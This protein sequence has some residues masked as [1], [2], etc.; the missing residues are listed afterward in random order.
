MGIAMAAGGGRRAARGDDV[1]KR[2][3]EGVGVSGM[4]AV[5]VLTPALRCSLGRHRALSGSAGTEPPL[6][7][8]GRPGPFGW[9]LAAGAGRRQSPAHLCPFG[10]SLRKAAFPRRRGV[11][12]AMQHEGGSRRRQQSRRRSHHP[13]GPCRGVRCQSHLRRA[14]GRAGQVDRGAAHP[15][16][17]DPSPAG[18]CCA[19]WL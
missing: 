19:A 10:R 3:A 8:V 7:A 15:G 13:R 5:A 17:W 2:D 9:A 18:L 11:P 12:E 16:A 1:S 6:P 14:D 4:A